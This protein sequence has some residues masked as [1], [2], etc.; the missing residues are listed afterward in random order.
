MRLRLLAQLAGGVL[1]VGHHLGR[2][3]ARLGLLLQ[4]LDRHLTVAD[5]GRAHLH[6]RDQLRVR[7][8]AHVLLVAVPAPGR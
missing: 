5:V 2:L 3:Q 1:L 4:Q 6:R 8:F 7:V